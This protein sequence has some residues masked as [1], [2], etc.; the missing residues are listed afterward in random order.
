[1]AGNEGELLV[2]GE[3]SARGQAPPPKWY[4]AQTLSGKERIAVV[5]LQRQSFRSFC[6][7]FLK[8]RKRARRLESAHIPLYPGYVFVS[9]DVDCDRWQSINGTLGVKRLIAFDS[10][11]PQ[12]MPDLVM[13]YLLSQSRAGR[14]TEPRKELQVGDVVRVV[15]GPFA[16]QMATIESLSDGGRVRVLLDILGGAI[17]VQLRSVAVASTAA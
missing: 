9:F 3:P 1:M 2:P 8:V 12:P 5:N 6:P 16:E 11:K 4:V 17:K 13:A 10:S 15:Q 7:Y 14:I